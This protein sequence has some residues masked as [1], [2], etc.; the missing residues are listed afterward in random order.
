MIPYPR[1]D[2]EIVRVGPFAIRWYGMMY[3]AGFA[4][5]YLLVKYQIR[6]KM[7]FLSP[8]FVSS[9][10]SYIILG[11]LIGARFGY[12]LVYDLR[13]YL[14]HP[15]EIFAVWHGGMSFHGGLVGSVIGG[16]LF[17]KAQRADF[18]QT[19]DLVA[20]T[21]PIGLGL[22]RIANFINGEL[23]GRVSDAPWAMVFPYG[24]TFPRHPSQLYEFLL[25]G[26]LLFAILWLIRNRGLRSGVMTAI[27][28]VLYGIFRSFAEI[29]RQ[30]DAQ[31][32]FVFGSF[33]MGQVLSGL[34]IVIGFFI[35]FL[36]KRTN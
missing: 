1:I 33:T 18:W 32:G 34:M 27:F 28:L 15:L 16:I 20:V 36:R 30:P 9:L 25:E 10:Y 14:S 7:L 3:L 13:D 21:A 22:G 35:L 4:A 23:Y 12:V 17:C 31:V 2:P 26:I 29:F 8:G 19:S 5:S 6:K 11:L 24:G